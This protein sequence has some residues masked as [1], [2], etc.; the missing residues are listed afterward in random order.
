[1]YGISSCLLKTLL[2]ISP[3]AYHQYKTKFNELTNKY[4]IDKGAT[5]F[6]KKM[7]AHDIWL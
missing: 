5:G 2:A 3:D 7:A 1:M 4:E 6:P